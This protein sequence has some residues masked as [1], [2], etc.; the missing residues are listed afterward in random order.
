MRVFCYLAF[1]FALCLA[2]GQQ[3]FSQTV[4]PDQRELI[5]SQAPSPFG[6]NASPSGVEGGQAV[7]TPNDSD[8]GE[9]QILKRVQ[10]YQPF[11]FSF[12]VPFYWT[13]NVALTRHGEMDD[14]V[15]APAVALFY[16]P[17]I[18]QTLYG[19]A[20]IR[21]QFFYY[22]KFDGFDFGSFDFEI[23]FRY[24]VPQFHNLQLRFEYDFNRLTNKD[25][26]DDFFSDHTFIA[27]A[28]MPF[29]IGRAQLVT[30]GLNE[31]ISV[32]AVPDSPRRNDYEGYIGYSANLTRD[33]SVNAVGRLVLRDYYHQQS[34]LDVSEILSLGANYR[35]T[36]SLSAG[37]V[38]TFAASQSNHS[39]FDYEVANIGGVAS[40][41]LR[42]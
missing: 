19:F 32:A 2:F 38:A 4:A 34:R 39:V 24:L 36:R 41:W 23:G 33:F 22:D 37:A 30:I 42:F 8:L 18:S 10:E 5:R 26:F 20:G 35:I 12:G 25:S 17:R 14:F 6:P 29:R 9:Q 15:V 1:V 7:S 21:Q 40:L 3:S 28:E 16:E 13:S 27:N 11:T 31:N